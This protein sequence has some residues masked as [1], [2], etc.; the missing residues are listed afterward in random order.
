MDVV[1]RVESWIANWSKEGESELCVEFACF[2]V[3]PD[4]TPLIRKV[5]ISSFHLT[6][7]LPTI[8]AQR[9]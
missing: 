2:F 1:T 7:I 8:F 9:L 3:A 4:L 5:E 6:Q